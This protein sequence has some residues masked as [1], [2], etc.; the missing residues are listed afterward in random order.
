MSKQKGSFSGETVLEVSSK[1]D[2]SEEDEEIGENGC[3]EKPC[4]ASHISF[5]MFIFAIYWAHHAR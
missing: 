2:P 1:I 5:E 3:L 4:M